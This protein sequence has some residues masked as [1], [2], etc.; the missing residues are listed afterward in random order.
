MSSPANLAY[1]I[2]SLRGFENKISPESGPGIVNCNQV[3]Y[4]T[5]A[6]FANL[7]I[8]DVTVGG[9]SAVTGNAS[10]DSCTFAG[11]L[12]GTGRNNLIYSY[13]KSF[14]ADEISNIGAGNST[15]TI[16]P[17]TAG[18]N[19]NFMPYKVLVIYHGSSV[20]A[21]E[22][23]GTNPLLLIKQDQSNDPDGGVFANINPVGF[24]DQAQDMIFSVADCTS[25]VGNNAQ[26]IS[27]ITSNTAL[28]VNA[29]NQETINAFT[30]QGGDKIALSVCILYTVFDRTLT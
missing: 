6:Q 17:T 8:N 14:T 11:N 19:K 23:N 7:K 20:G 30:V 5:L 2:Q 29:N 4:T 26:S 3:V 25:L 27:S 18:T 21:A 16:L 9:T 12:T 24:M 15:L 13:K 22:L 10:L 28:Y 1:G